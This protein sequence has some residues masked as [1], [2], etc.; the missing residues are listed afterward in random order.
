MES[1]NTAFHCFHVIE[2]QLR[3]FLF[4][5][6]L[7]KENF[8]L[9]V[10]MVD[11]MLSWAF[12]LYYINH[13]CWM[14]VFICNL[15]SLYGKDVYNEFCKG[16]ISVKKSNREFSSIG[17]DYTH[18]QNNKIIKGDGDVIGIFDHEKVLREWAVCGPGVAYMFQDLPD[19]DEDDYY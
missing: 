7:Y 14:S 12:A 4:I 1:S 18:E 16:H 6:S 13:A 15:K 3:L 17:E 11:T 2:L 10:C 9:F 5:Q 19:I 8:D